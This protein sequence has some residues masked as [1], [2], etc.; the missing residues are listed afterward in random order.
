MIRH[1]GF[2]NKKY[3]SWRF[4]NL[5]RR[6]INNVSFYYYDSQGRPQIICDIC[7]I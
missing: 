6:N 4:G 2:D 3:D 1:L 5:T 7:R